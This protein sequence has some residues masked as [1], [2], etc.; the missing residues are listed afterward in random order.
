MRVPLSWLNEFVP[1]EGIAPARIAEVLT[2]AG[3]EVDAVETVEPSFSGVVIGK[4]LSVE[5]HPN[6][7]KLRV[8]QVS[9][10]TET[11]QVVCGASN[12]RPG[13]RVPFAKIGAKL[14]MADG[15][16]L[17]IKKSALRGV[18]SYGMLCAAD[19]LCMGENSNGIF[20]LEEDAVIGKDFSEGLG[21]IIF[22]IS[23]TPN[24]GHCLSI[25]GVARELA[26][27]LDL[28]LKALP[29]EKPAVV[30]G[31][32][33]V[34]VKADATYAPKYACRVLE[35]LKVGPSPSWLK[36]RLEAVGLRS[37]NNIVDCTNYVM[38][39]CG[40]PLHAFDADKV[41][42]R[43]IDVRLAKEGENFTTLDN[44]NHKLTLKDLLICDGAHP[45]ALGGIM[46]GLNSEVSD[47]THSIILESAYFIPQAIAHTRRR[48]GIL[49]DA[50]TRFERGVDPEGVMRAL[51]RAST[52]IQQ[53][54]GGTAGKAVEVYPKP[55]ASKKINCRLNRVTTL[56]GL[57]LVQGEL[58]AT[59]R[60]LQL[61]GQWID[62][63]TLQVTVPLFRHDINEEVDL[64]EE[65]ARL[66]GYQNMGKGKQQSS[67]SLIP[68]AALYELERE[69]RARLTSFGLQELMTC[70]L[71]SPKM[72]SHA[73]TAGEI[74]HVKNPT[75][76]D[77]SILRPSLLPCLLEVACYNSNHQQTALSGFEIGRVYYKKEKEVIEQP[78]VGIV[79]AGALNP[80][81]WSADVEPADFY[82]LKGMV[83][84][85]LKALGAHEEGGS[86]RK[87]SNPLF[88]PGR[89][90]ALS[91]NDVDWGVLGE[92]HPSILREVGYNGR[93]YYAEL[94]LAPLLHARKEK[95]NQRLK[96]LPAFPGSERDWTLTVKEELPAGELL[97]TIR[98]TKNR[99]LDQVSLLGIYRSEKLGSGW[100][101]VTLRLSYRDPKKTLR[102]EAVDQEHAAIVDAV[103]KQVGT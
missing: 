72:A 61:D 26:G 30:E 70:D 100:K 8:A 71:I 60:R 94:N 18:D 9:D 39:E 102:Q 52:L 25:Y 88:H 12:C 15:E 32:K 80:H 85:L 92:I 84:G 36:K 97:N 43:K 54:A 83:E 81:H 87:S 59:L 69:V 89:Q 96:P 38:W 35:G 46:G 93:L 42:G 14:K 63:N 13:I 3:L 49:T 2:G 74:V 76:I 11:V 66:Y 47:T 103:N 20:E 77:Q 86:Y 28:P 29:S 75:S 40:Q 4:V 23:L 7:E 79:L 1:L 58:L 65:V 95:V 51:D 56:L 16:V 10:G 62:E 34:T 53:V 67:T 37:I 44:K 31:V 19:E 41:E 78:M 98:Q 21:D 68:H 57:E 91:V 99:L 17:K 33:P 64:I 90:A 82:S 48:L 73:L 55:L 24:L 27:M 6:A 22:E 5:Q 45:I 101:N 50:S